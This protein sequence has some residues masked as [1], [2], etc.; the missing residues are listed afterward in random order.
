MRRRLLMGRYA[1]EHAASQEVCFDVVVHVESTHRLFADVYDVEFDYD[2]V[3]AAVDDAIG[4]RDHHILQ[5]PL[6]LDIAARVLKLPYV[7]EVE[8]RSR[9]TQIYPDIDYAG[10]SVKLKSS[11]VQRIHQALE[12]DSQLDRRGSPLPSD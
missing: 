1:K 6:V 12:Q 9:K 2:D 4:S 11:D 10:F 5:E 7:L 8:V 3:V